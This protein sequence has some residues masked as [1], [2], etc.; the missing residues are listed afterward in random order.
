[1]KT[2]GLGLEE[3]YESLMVC[4]CCV[5]LRCGLLCDAFEFSY[6]DVHN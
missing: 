6:T 5:V 3:C 2:Y 4:G 1:M